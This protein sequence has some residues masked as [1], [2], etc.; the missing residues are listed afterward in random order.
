MF[1][2]VSFFFGSVHRW[3]GASKGADGGV[4]KKH[5]SKLG[6]GSGVDR[7]PGEGVLQSQLLQK[8]YVSARASCVMCVKRGSFQVA[9]A[10]RITGSHYFYIGIHIPSQKALGLSK[11]HIYDKYKSYPITFSEGM[12]IQKDFNGNQSVVWLSLEPLYWDSQRHGGYLYHLLQRKNQGEPAIAR[13][14][15][16]GIKKK[17]SS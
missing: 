7:W 10:Q 17:N 6:C 14:K 3:I 9:A 4:W 16:T 12:W 1:P 8:V 5:A 13:Q 11:R 2:V 15:G